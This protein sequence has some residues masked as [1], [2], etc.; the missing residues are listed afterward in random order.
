MQRKRCTARDQPSQGADVDEPE[1]VLVVDEIPETS[2]ALTGEDDVKLQLEWMS[3][4]LLSSV[5]QP[6][7]VN[8]DWPECRG[9]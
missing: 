9:I 8:A 4:S 5:I 1:F 7:L 3:V 6:S 2:K